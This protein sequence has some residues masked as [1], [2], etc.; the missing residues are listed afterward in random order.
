MNESMARSIIR[1]TSVYH[2][3]LSVVHLLVCTHVYLSACNLSTMCE[4]ICLSIILCVCACLCD[5]VFVCLSI[6]LRVCLA[7]GQSGRDR[8]LSQSVSLSVCRSVDRSIWLCACSRVSV[9]LNSSV[10]YWTKDITGQICYM[11][12]NYW[13][14]YFITHG[15]NPLKQSHQERNGFNRINKCFHT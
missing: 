11:K 7:I 5:R 14:R 9:C 6:C 15:S 3:C 8:S 1:L 4:L 2:E 12:I 10:T 13:A